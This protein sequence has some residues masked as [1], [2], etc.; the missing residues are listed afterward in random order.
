MTLKKYNLVTALFYPAF[1]GAWLYEVMD[2]VFLSFTTVQ[3]TAIVQLA[4][5]A[6]LL[7][8]YIVDYLYTFQSPPKK[9]SS[10]QFFLDI[11]ILFC[12]YAGLKISLSANYDSMMTGIWVAM[13]VMKLLAIAWK[14]VEKDFKGMKYD[15]LFFLIYSIGAIFFPGAIWFFVVVCFIDAM[16]YEVDFIQQQSLT[17]KT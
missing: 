13:S 10:I 6:S 1:L 2:A 7:F 8:H 14:W 5:S 12:L 16:C 4:L 15:G 9:Y 11:G 3:K 17:N